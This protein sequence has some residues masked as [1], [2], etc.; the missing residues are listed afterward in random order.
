MYHKR[1][2]AVDINVPPFVQVDSLHAGQTYVS[3]HVYSSEHLD[4][5]YQKMILMRFDSSTD[6]TAYIYN[7]GFS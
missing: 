1:K 4:W 2:A 7:L 5:L 3:F 6:D